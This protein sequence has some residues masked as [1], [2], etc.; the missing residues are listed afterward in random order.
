MRITDHIQVTPIFDHKN[1]R[2]F[3]II[4]TNPTPEANF[5][6]HRDTMARAYVKLKLSEA[7]I[8]QMVLELQKHLVEPLDPKPLLTL[9]PGL[10]ED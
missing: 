4:V 8:L 5:T 10:K 1:G 9:V 2:R 3:Q 6:V 7:D